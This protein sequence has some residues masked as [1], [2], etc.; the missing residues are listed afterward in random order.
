MCFLY[1]IKGNFVAKTWTRSVDFILLF[2]ALICL[3]SVV[4]GF[5]Y[6]SVVR[7]LK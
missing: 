3:A 2:T 5:G 6:F 4:V 1:I 7:P